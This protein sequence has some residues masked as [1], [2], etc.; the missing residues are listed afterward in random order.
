MKLF[1]LLAFLAAPQNGA[2]EKCTLSGTVVNAITGEP[3]A[4]VRILASGAGS[5]SGSTPSTVT[6]AKGRFTLVNLA[7]G[8]YELKG[9]RNGFL[10]GVY[11]A[12]Q[13]EGN[14]TPVALEAGQEIKDL[15][16][17][18]TPFGV[19]A[20]TIRDS[21]GEALARLT[22]TVH[23]VRFEHGRRQIVQA[24]GAYTDDLGQY[25]IP[26]LPPGKYY[27]FAEAVKAADFG[28]MSRAETI[29]EDHSPKGSTQPQTLV[30]A[31]YPGVQD[32]ASA[33]TVEVGAGARVT[34]IDI[35]LARSHTVT[36]KGRASAPPGMRMSGVEMDYA[37]AGDAHLGLHLF[38]AVSQ[39]DEFVFHDVPPGNYVLTASAGAPVKAFNG[40]MEMFPED[41]KARQPLQVGTEPVDNVR[42]I[43]QAGADVTGHV[44]VV[45]DDKAELAG[46]FVSIDEGD[47]DPELVPILA[48]NSFKRTLPVGHYW[49]IPELGGDLVVRSMTAQ[50]RS[51]LDDGLTVTGPANI[52]LEITL[53]HEGGEL[54]GVVLDAADKPVAGAT[55]V[56]AP[57]GK[58][59]A[60]TDLFRD[61]Q[62][63]QY[64][65]FTVEGVAPGDYRL[66]AWEDVDPGMWWD[67]DFR[68]KYVAKSTAVTIGAKEKAQAKVHLAKD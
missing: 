34:G 30:P 50:G 38:A 54:V 15:Q 28:S 1:L 25:R 14:G 46:N 4:K 57:Q 37:G 11:G 53:A 41:F 66:F 10:D 49:V 35:T 6:D 24:G 19:I 17:K 45:D 12:R 68:K 5:D 16:L 26:D 62:S 21:D 13:A 64:G 63:D 65:R 56:L 7:P 23:R 27:V 31:L 3:L 42:L 48:G 29:T 40:T 33:K 58:Q 59:N 32:P 20:G 61:I 51:V 9:Q 55:V 44:T 60:R 52:D 8:R 22:V 2:T 43:M 18:L 36:V 39:K 47:G 67:P